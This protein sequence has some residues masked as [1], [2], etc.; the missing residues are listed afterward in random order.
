MYGTGE[1]GGQRR[2][3]KLEGIGK[4]G[5]DG[6]DVETT[7]VGFGQKM[8][9]IGSTDGIGVEMFAKGKEEALTKQ[10]AR[11]FGTASE[12]VDNPC[13]AGTERAAE[14]YQFVPRL[15]AMDN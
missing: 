15:D 11:L 2:E 6:A 7:F 14:G 3:G 8:V 10:L 13:L 5:V 9:G 1:L 12:A 4:A